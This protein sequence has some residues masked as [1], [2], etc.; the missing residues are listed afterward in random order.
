M[1]VEVTCGKCGAVIYTMRILKPVKDVVKTYSKCPSCGQ[2]LSSSD[3][4]ISVS[5]T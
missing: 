5:K 4:A 1:S 2:A 3:F